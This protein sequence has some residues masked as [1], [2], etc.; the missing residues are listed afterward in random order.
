MNSTS[1]EQYWSNWSGDLRFRPAGIEVPKDEQEIINIIEKAAIA[2]RNI[3]AVGASHSCSPIFVTNDTLLSV[4]KLKGFYGYNKDR[5]TATVGAGMTVEETGNALFDVGLGMEN[6][7]HVNKQA[8]AGAISTGTH[9]AGKML[10]NLSGQVVGVRIVTATGQIRE[11]DQ[12]RNQEMMKAIRVSLGT[13]GIISRVTL[14]VLPAFQL[15]RRQYC[16]SVKDCLNNLEYLTNNNRNFCFYW[17]PRRDDVSIRIWNLPGKGTLNLPF[18]KLY[19][20]YTGWGKDVLPTPHELKYNELEYS[21]DAKIAPTCFQE[22]RKLIKEKHRKIVGWR[23]LFRPV[24]GD[25]SYLSNSYGRDTIAITVHQNASLP[26]KE[27]F[28][29]VEKIFQDHEGRPHWG[30]KHSLKAKDLKKLYPMWDR[31]QEIRKQ[32]DPNGI[33]LNQYIKDVF[34]NE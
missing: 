18:G 29:D 22:V 25:D 30:K 7:G 32:M 26:Y 11:F 28:D 13:L 21:F 16:A 10:T 19:K 5:L 20:E 12:E 2:G 3:R 33:F 4:E 15:S 17:Y 6:T 27:Y 9:G 1:G 23:V 31:F 24:A 34:Q 14:K 8:L